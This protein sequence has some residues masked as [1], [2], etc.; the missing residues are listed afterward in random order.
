[1]VNVNTFC[2]YFFSVL[3]DTYVIEKQYRQTNSTR[4][5]I[6]FFNFR[7]VF[8]CFCMMIL[9]LIRNICNLKQNRQRFL[10]ILVL[11]SS[12]KPNELILFCLFYK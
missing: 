4:F 12:S 7:N 3:N 2:V 6:V 9:S 8:W 10:E 5:H 11:K 1:M